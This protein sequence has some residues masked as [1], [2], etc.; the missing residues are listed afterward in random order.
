MN[1][2]KYIILLEKSEAYM[3]QAD[4]CLRFTYPMLQE[5]KILL[6]ALNALF[7][8]N[9]FAIGSILEFECNHKRIPSAGTNFETKFQLMKQ[10][11]IEPFGIE[12]E[13]MKM[14]RDLKD[15]VIAHSESP[16]EFSR[17]NKF[18]I[19]N[20]NYEIKEITLSNLQM[21]FKKTK[22]FIEKATSIINQ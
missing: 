21:I 13:Y 12:T 14:I 16:V 19:C 11:I 10:Y 22:L 9:S 8:A 3:K 1:Q 18:I 15:L 5:A 17:G 4:Q 7:L 6:T 2:P 20:D